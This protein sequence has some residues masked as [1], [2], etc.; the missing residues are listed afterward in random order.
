MVLIR[1]FGQ[2]REL[3]TVLCSGVR[4]LLEGELP[5]GGDDNATS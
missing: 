3:R 1:D 2:P 4:E 5:N